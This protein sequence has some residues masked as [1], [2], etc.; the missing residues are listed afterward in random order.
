MIPYVV[1]VFVAGVLAILVLTRV[2]PRHRNRG[3]LAWPDTV[4]LTATLAGLLA[5]RD[6]YA[7][8]YCGPRPNPSG[9]LF[10]PVRSPWD[11]E[12]PGGANGWKRLEGP[13]ADAD[14]ADVLRRL[15]DQDMGVRVRL[16]AVLPPADIKG[17]E[18]GLCYLY[19]PGSTSP[20]RAGT[21]TDRFVLPPVPEMRKQKDSPQH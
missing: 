17:L 21:A 15:E 9:L 12:L 13:D 10:V 7:L 8:H 14:V 11:W 5:D 18:W 3:R 20:R 16:H 2:K 4:G 19:T 6:G 1:L